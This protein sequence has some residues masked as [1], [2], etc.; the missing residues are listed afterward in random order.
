MS[1]G[2]KLSIAIE[3][4]LWFKTE[5]FVP[6]FLRMMDCPAICYNHCIF[7]YIIATNRCWLRGSMKNKQWQIRNISQGF[8]D[9][10]LCSGTISA[11]RKSGFQWQYLLL[12][13]SLFVTQAFLQ[14]CES[15]IELLLLLFDNLWWK[16]RIKS[17][18]FYECMYLMYLLKMCC[19]FGEIILKLCLE[20]K[21]YERSAKVFNLQYL[22]LSN[23]NWLIF[24]ITLNKLF[25]FIY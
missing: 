15:L 2:E 14:E 9:E 3:K 16:M 20:R 7:L 8:E 6:V 22:V 10:G 18:C 5:R 4:S 17:K 1:C 12:S 23:V 13:A 24:I 21:K 19:F 11:V 25:S